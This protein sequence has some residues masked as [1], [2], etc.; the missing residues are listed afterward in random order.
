[1]AMGLEEGGRG[2][3]L[4]D[5]NASQSWKGKRQILPAVSSRDQPCQHQTRETWDQTPDLH[6]EGPECVW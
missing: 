1:M 6:I 3:E 4:R 5:V 2:H